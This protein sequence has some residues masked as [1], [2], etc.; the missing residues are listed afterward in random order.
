MLNS[1][2]SSLDRRETRPRAP[3]V[4]PCR[5]VLMV[6]TDLD[7]IGGVRAVVCG[8]RDAGLFERIRLRY[9]ATHR[10]GSPWV[11]MAAALRGWTRVAL[12]LL[13]LDAPLVHVHLASRASF[14][15]KLAVCL[16][17]RSARRPYLLHLHG[18]EFMQF[19]EQESAAPVRRLI[20][21]TF[22]GAALV[23]ALSEEWRERVLRICPA[24]RVEV[25]PN[26]VALPGLERVRRLDRREPTLLL[27]GELCRRKG[28]YDLIPAAA[29][30]AGEFPHLKLVCA[31]PGERAPARELAA[32]CGIGGQVFCPGWL[33]GER[34][35]AELAGA[36][37]FVLPSYAEGMPMALLEAMAWGLPVV[38]TPVGGVP[39]V[40]TDG[41]NGL[42]VA[43]GDIEGLVT[44]LGRLLR[45]PALR[46]R[47]GRAARGTI[48]AR[49]SVESAVE[50][51]CGIYH[52]FGIRGHSN[53]EV[54]S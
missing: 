1:T 48:E 44:A 3:A 28:V 4:R 45:D 29:R 26:A 54:A 17:A 27:L 49:F 6:G 12:L 33:E 21:W 11:K 24:A 36:T 35:R 41:V 34:K 43:P 14:W 53:A 2:A 47:L 50:R 51:L 39:Q 40:V 38:A 10:Y 5:S 25:L 8:Y 37:A 18:A 52:R 30:L 42:L 32:A 19:Y 46:E 7:G 15:R 31:G 22:A 23:I 9:V 20:R 13:T 16:M